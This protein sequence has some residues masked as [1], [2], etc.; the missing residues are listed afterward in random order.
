MN[1]RVLIL[2]ALLSFEAWA[3]HGRNFQI[4]YDQSKGRYQVLME[5]Q[6]IAVQRAKARVEFFQTGQELLQKYLKL[7]KAKYIDDEGKFQ[8][9]YEISL[10][11]RENINKLTF[12]FLKSNEL[13][14]R[15]SAHRALKFLEQS[16]SEINQRIKVS[17]SPDENNN[18][19][20]EI[21]SKKLVDEKEK[22]ESIYETA[23]SAG[24]NINKD[25]EVKTGI[26]IPASIQRSK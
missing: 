14:G 15:V 19:E 16:M 8:D 25:T 10:T 12:G 3:G 9:S 13:R 20:L 23:K 6:Q 5:A 2:I 22:M 7:I 1:L 24:L 17:E 18:S 21:L 26:R 4:E 11:D